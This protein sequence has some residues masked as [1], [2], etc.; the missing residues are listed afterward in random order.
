[1]A[2]DYVPPLSP[3]IIWNFSGEDYTPPLSPAIIWNFGVDDDG[4]TSG[5]LRANY[6]ILLTM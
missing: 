5:L 1:M 3:N 6:M 4:T 2:E